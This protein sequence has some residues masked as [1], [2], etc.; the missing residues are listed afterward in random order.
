MRTPMRTII[1]DPVW[2][3]LGWRRRHDGT[4]T[5]LGHVHDRDPEE[6][7]RAIVEAFTRSRG[8]LVSAAVELGVCRRHL[9]RY[10]WALDLWPTVDE[11]RRAN[12]MTRGVQSTRV[13]SAEGRVA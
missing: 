1:P 9:L 6:A 11:I 12:G 13:D 8:R 5:W 10:L 3:R 2:Q 4:K 7:K